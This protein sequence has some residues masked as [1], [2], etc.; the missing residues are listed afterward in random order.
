MSQKPERPHTAEQ[1]AALP[2]E[3]FGVASY[4][5]TDAD[6][7]RGYAEIN[8][9]RVEVRDGIQRVQYPLPIDEVIFFSEDSDVT[10]YQDSDGVRW[11]LG[12]YRDGR[13]F[14]QRT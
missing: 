4:E 12:L 7:K 1:I 8:G 13:W 10:H 6:R 3:G 14:R 11:R 2:E 5:F 9:A